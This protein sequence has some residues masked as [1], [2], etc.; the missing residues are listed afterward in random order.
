[1]IKDRPMFREA[2]EDTIATFVLSIAF[3][4]RPYTLGI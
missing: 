1:M 4:L 2:S 3:G